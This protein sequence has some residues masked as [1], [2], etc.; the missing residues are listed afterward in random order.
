M[1]VVIL[2]NEQQQQELS[3]GVQN[4]GA[5]VWIKS[6][7]ELQQHN[8][9]VFMNL[10]F[11]KDSAHMDTVKNFSGVFVIHSVAETLH[12]LS[13]T[14]T[15]I[16]AWPGFLL[17][18]WIEAATSDDA[19]KQLVE[20]AFALLGKKVQWLPDEPGFVSAR[21]IG[22]IINEAYLALEE[23]VSTKE[24]INTAMKLGTAYPYGPFEWA[25]KIGLENITALLQKMSE[26]K[27]HYLPAKEML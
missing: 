5:I 19:S 12:D 13:T 4:S 7:E 16:N 20:A 8:A 22:M 10:L 27:P 14:A 15:R 26:S 11:A 1:Q 21:A 9:D 23:G 6:I 17:G 25:E 2:A 24:E 3:S 18:Q